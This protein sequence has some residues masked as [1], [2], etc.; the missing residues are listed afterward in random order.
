MHPHALGH[1]QSVPHVCMPEVPHDCMLPGAQTP[2]LLHVV[3]HAPVLLSQVADNVPQLPHE[4]DGGLPVHPHAL[5]H[6]QSVPHV[7]MPEVPQLCMLPGAQA[8]S[9]LHAP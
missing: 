4:P 9:P 5:G 6:L 8:P 2:L 3:V 7:C 1:L